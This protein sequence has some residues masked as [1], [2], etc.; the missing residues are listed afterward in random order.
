MEYVSRRTVYFKNPGEGNTV[1]TLSLS[2]DRADELGIRNIVVASSSG[3]TGVAALEVFK[4]YNLV[5]VT[6]VTGYMK[7]NEVRIKPEFR[8]AI[9][10]CGGVILTAA[11]AFGTL[12]RAVHNK[13]GA[14]QIDEIV[15][16]VLRLFSEGVKV[17]CEIA[18]MAVDAGH[19]ST[20]EEAIAIGGGGSGADT[21]IV[22]RPSNTHAFFDMRIREIICK[23]R[24]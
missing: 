20:D 2:K 22:V 14:M 19:F 9:E 7:P 8:E 12:G 18:C 15:A 16:H 4:D 24:C 17:G 11:H 23:P 1:K 5:V 21:A 10:A 3:R 6:S 13:F